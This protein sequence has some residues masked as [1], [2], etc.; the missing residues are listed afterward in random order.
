MTAPVWT[1]LDLIRRELGEGL[2]LLADGDLVMVDLL[3]GRLLRVDPAGQ[4]GMRELA[5]LDVPLGAVAPLSHEPGGWLAAA[6][7]GFAVLRAGR[8]QWVDKP[9][10]AHVGKRRMNDAAVD[11]AGRFWAGS[12]AYDAAPGAGSLYRLDADGTVT[13][14]LDG[15]TIPNGPVFTADG[16]TMYFADSAPGTI[17][18]FDVDPATGR[19][20]GQRRFADV[21]DA[22]P[23][24]MLVDDEGHLWVA[25]WGAGQ[26]RRYRPD[27]TLVAV[28]PLPASQPTS[29]A[30][31]RGSTPMLVVTTATQGLD[32]LDIGASHDGRLLMTSAPTS[33]PITRSAGLHV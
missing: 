8:P 7:T 17:D 15:L 21:P 10:D 11:A 23:D 4:A 2:R 28:L 31:T 1:P 19:L 30:L 5:H 20:S 16:A 32:S 13:Q 29:V 25:V 12:M 18:I 9:E 3:A 24:G 27:G 6:G 14:V 22:N 26:V 33:G